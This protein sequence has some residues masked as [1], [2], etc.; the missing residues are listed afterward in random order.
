MVNRFL[1]PFG[2]RRSM[3]GPG[4]LSPLF[5]LQREMNRMFDDVF[6]GSAPAE[7]RERAW[8]TPRIDVC[9]TESEIR[10]SAEI[11]GVAQSDV[12][13][14][15]EDDMLSISGEKKEERERERA[16]YHVSERSF[17][18]FQRRI[19]LPFS[20]DPEQVR[21]SFDSGLLTITIPRTDQV[22]ERRRRIDIQSGSGS[23]AG[24]AEGTKH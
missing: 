16:Y 3:A 18:R 5:D 10:V 22:R 7:P 23:A 20:P 19:Q 14:S 24:K 2:G 4:A 17:G 21:A 15:I 11:P 13:V 8:V 9:E 12:D 6:G 1:A